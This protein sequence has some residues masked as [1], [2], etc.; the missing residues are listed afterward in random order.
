SVERDRAE[1]E[2]QRAASEAAKAQQVSDYL[3]SLFRAADPAQAAGQEITAIELVQRGVEQVEGLVDDPMLQVSMFRVLGQVN[4]A[5]G[6]YPVANELLARALAILDSSPL[7]SSPDRAELLADLA[8]SHF[9]LGQ[10]KEAEQFNQ[11]ALAEMPQDDLLRRA[12]VLTNLGIVYI[13]TSRY[14]EAQSLLLQAVQAHQEADPYSPDHA[15]ARNALGTLLSRQGRHEEAL[16]M[17]EEAVA[18]RV[19]LF[20][21]DHPATSIA[22]SNLGIALLESGD[23][24]GAEIHLLEALAVDERLLGEDH[25]SLSILLMQVASAKRGMGEMDEAIDYLNRALAI[26]RM[27]FEENHPSIA[28]ALSGLGTVYLMSEEWAEA[29]RVLEQAIAID[30]VAF[31]PASREIA[32][33]LSQLGTVRLRQGKLDEAETLLQRSHDIAFELFGEQHSLVGRPLRYLAEIYWERGEKALAQEVS[34][35]SLAILT[36]EYGAEN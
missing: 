22:V 36:L 11:T 34:H 4:Q 26:Q 28:T 31:G 16:A 6:S 29:E 18:L 24:A 7:P 2:A 13:L 9:Q 19:N 10:F 12:P 15:T 1:A 27:H 8:V 25:P 21:T 23:P 3:V 35:Q 33:N 30:E 5:L 17:L 14:E 32:I 20:G